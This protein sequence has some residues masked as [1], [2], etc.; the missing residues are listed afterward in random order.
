ME[1]S[2]WSPSARKKYLKR[3][4]L[5][6]RCLR[7]S[8]PRKHTSKSVKRH[9]LLV[10]REYC[11]CTSIHGVKYLGKSPQRKLDIVWWCL[12]LSTAVGCSILVICNLWIKWRNEPVIV[13]FSQRSTPI[14]EIPF[15]AGM[16]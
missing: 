16:L 7:I 15:P 14:W 13:T 12:F 8:C 6:G 4:I 10:L 11:E 2:K 9:G 3:Q 5:G 1:R